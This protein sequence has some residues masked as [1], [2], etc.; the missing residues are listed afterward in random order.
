[1]NLSYL[2]HACWRVD[3]GGTRILFDPVGATFHD[4]VFS[5]H[6][7]RQVDWDAV[8]ADLIVVSH[9]HPDHFDV[10]TLHTLAERDPTVV[11][12]TSDPLVGRACRRLGFHDV[13][14]VGA[15]VRIPLDDGAL[16]TT[17]SLATFPE[18]GMIV[19]SE[20]GTVWN[21]VDS[22]LGDP[23][24]VR[25]ILADAAVALGR[26][27]LARGPDLALAR[28][29]PLMQV[30]A[31]VMGRLDFPFDRYAAEI[32]RVVASGARTVVPAAAGHRHEPPGDWLRHT[33][34]PVS[35]SRF[36]RDLAR[37]GGPPSLPAVVGGRYALRAGATTLDSTGAAALVAVE[38]DADPR[39][40]DPLALPPL[41]DPGP[42][43][44]GDADAVRTFATTTLR[45]AVVR[46]APRLPRPCRLVLRVVW[47]GG[48]DAYTYDVDGD[49]T[50]TLRDD[51]DWDLLDAIAGSRLAA[52][53]RGESH[54]GRA[55][56]SGQLRTRRRA[57]NVGPDG[58]SA[59]RTP[60][61][62]LYEALPYDVATERW[63]EHQLTALGR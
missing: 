47:P 18:W 57:Y 60:A 30:D 37:R 2:G 15:G 4:G 3:L 1:M 10:A 13:A 61:V 7:Q 17:P 56:L 11:V 14:V 26:P 25:R 58:L 53:L 34:F 46:L 38:P 42:V 43:Q 41:V 28:W 19:A 54:W 21:Q 55:L 33:S 31:H 9:R 32:E 63:V 49:V 24:N 29:A 45:D 48:V 27:E 50:L 51:P 6:P 39:T 44:P 36:R 62:F 59:V 20:Q 52:V 22:A 8:A 12:V 35:E 23:G 16:Y 40:W 5:T